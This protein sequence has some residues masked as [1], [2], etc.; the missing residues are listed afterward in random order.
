VRKV[1]GEILKIL[2]YQTLKAKDGI[3]AMAM[4]EAHK[5]AVSLALLDVVM[6]HCGGMAL[7]KKI[8]SIRPALPIIFL[9]GYDKEHV[10]HGHQPLANS[11]ILTHLRQH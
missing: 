8:R 9:T 11:Q 3:K 5:D 10:L 7:A 4:F 2:G 1:T 6:P